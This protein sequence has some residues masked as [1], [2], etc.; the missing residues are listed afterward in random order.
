MRD[1]NQDCIDVIL[2]FVEAY[3][4][5]KGIKVGDMVNNL[6]SATV[7]YAA[8][9]L[10]ENQDKAKAAVALTDAFNGKFLIAIAENEHETVHH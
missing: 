4:E 7:T 10:P 6:L 1:P 9:Y 5:K 3:A 2:A 8:Y